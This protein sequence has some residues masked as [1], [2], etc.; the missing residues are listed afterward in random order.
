MD[1]VVSGFALGLLLGAAKIGVIGTIVC[2]IGWWR[3]HRTLRRL[4]A[5]LPEP[6][7]LSERL[8]NLEQMADYSASQ[9]ERL[10]EVQDSLARQLSA[11]AAKAIL[12]EPR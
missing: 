3:T 12:P 5:A 8:A 6:A 7:I 9:M 2:G 11:P 10:I 1:P 4:E